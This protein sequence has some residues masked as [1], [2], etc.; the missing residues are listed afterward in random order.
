MLLASL[1]G[2]LPTVESEYQV[3]LTQVPPE[4]AER[5]TACLDAHIADA[6]EC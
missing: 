4:R 3:T 5:D 1:T 6:I 2:I